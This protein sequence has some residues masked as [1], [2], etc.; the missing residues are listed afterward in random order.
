MKV[1]NSIPLV[2][3]NESIM[4]RMIQRPLEIPRRMFSSPWVERCNSIA[5]Q[6]YFLYISKSYPKETL[7]VDGRK[8]L[9]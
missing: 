7:T 4:N 5:H 1:L 3:G 9:F 8:M 2:S 6:K